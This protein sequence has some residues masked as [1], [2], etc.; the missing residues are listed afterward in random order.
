MMALDDKFGFTKVITIYPPR[1]SCGGIL[2]KTTNVNHQGTM[3]RNHEFFVQNLKPILPVDN[4]I[5]DWISEDFDLQVALDE[6]SE[7]SQKSLG[8][9]L[10]IP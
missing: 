1:N 4:Q 3:T 6:K 2:L 5:F 8:F 10:L 7:E 9:I